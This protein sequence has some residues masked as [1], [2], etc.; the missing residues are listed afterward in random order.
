MTP[1]EL[2]QLVDKIK[3]AEW[4]WKDFIW[5]DSKGLREFDWTEPRSGL[6]KIYE[7][8]LAMNKIMDIEQSPQSRRENETVVKAII[9]MA[10][11][12]KRILRKKALRLQGEQL[13]YEKHVV[14]MRRRIKEENPRLAK[15][16]PPP[17]PKEKL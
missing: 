8:I 1:L 7:I 4:L 12:L 5:D 13:K 16:P 10:L 9:P 3:H 2:K 14:L 17:K 11:K 15:L 6:F